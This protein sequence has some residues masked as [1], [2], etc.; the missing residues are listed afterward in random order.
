MFGCRIWDGLRNEMLN[1]QHS[2]LL[3]WESIVLVV[4]FEVIDLA[5]SFGLS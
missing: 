3:L 4:E 1:S 2:V 5:G